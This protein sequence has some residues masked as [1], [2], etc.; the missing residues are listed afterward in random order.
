MS[1]FE[2]LI[3]GLVALFV[4]GKVAVWLLETVIDFFSPIKHRF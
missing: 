3:V 1:I 4:F 2:F